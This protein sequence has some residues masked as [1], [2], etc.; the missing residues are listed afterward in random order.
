M[1]DST[2]ALSDASHLGIS[3]A[4][5]LGGSVFLGLKADE[6]LGTK[7]YLTLGGGLFGAVVGFYYLYREVYGK[8][9][10]ADKAGTRKGEDPSRRGPEEDRPS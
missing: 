3:Y 6:K 5:I 9:D 8:R 2:R 10:P 4:V 1:R 7:P